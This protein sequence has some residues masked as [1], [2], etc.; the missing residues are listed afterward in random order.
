MVIGQAKPVFL[1]TGVS[2]DG[3]SRKE[4]GIYVAVLRELLKPQKFVSLRE[5]S[6]SL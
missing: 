5:I 3:R 4:T 2:E 6:F 1:A